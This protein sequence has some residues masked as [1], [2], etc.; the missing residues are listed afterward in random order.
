MSPVELESRFDVYS[1]QYILTIEVEAKLVI[2]MTKTSIYPAAT[3][4]LTDLA[5]ASTAASEMGI[6]MNN[7]IAAGV[8]NNING[9]MAAV[10]KL[11]DAMA[12]EDHGSEEEHMQFCAN[13][14]R[15]LMD[16]ARENV[17]ALESVVADDLWP[18]PTY[19][20]MLYIK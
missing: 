1:E 3:R 13:T 2:N 14:I 4:Y 19:Q 18:L 8:A 15:S 11:E 20:E 5:M 10:S 16:E 7:S 17:D 6:E 9:M 12:K